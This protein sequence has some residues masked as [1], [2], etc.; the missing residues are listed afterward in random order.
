MAQHN[1]ATLRRILELIIN[2]S[3]YEL[4]GSLRKRIDRN[5][6]HVMLLVHLQPLLSTAIPEFDLDIHELDDFNLADIGVKTFKFVMNSMIRLIE[7]NSE[8][9][10]KLLK[11]EQL[12]VTRL[13]KYM[14]QMAAHLDK[15]P[16]HIDK[17]P[18]KGP[19]EDTGKL[20]VRILFT[21]HSLFSY[22]ISLNV[23]LTRL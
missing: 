23:F 2:E 3:C 16:V 15:M 21:T 19:P 7:K 10:D 20:T 12:T 22:F 4:D 17:G 9:T 6:K 14:D 1:T 8:I 13:S 5:S 11:N 18:R